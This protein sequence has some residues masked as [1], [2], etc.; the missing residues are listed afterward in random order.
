MTV[1]GLR[2]FLAL[3]VVLHHCVISYGFH[4]TGEWKLPPSPYY[5]I[6][7]QAGVSVFFMITAFLFWGRL[8]DEGKRTDWFALY[9]NRLFRI[10]PLYWVVIASMLLVVAIKT[11]F[12]MAVPPAEL[13][14]QVFQWL[15]PG[16]IKAPPTV[17]GYAATSTITAG[18]TWTLYFEWMFY[19]SLPLLGIAAVKRT[20]LGFLP[21]CIWVIFVLPDTL[22]NQYARCFVAMFAIGM[23]AASIVRRFRGMIGDSALKSMVAV[24]LLAYTLLNRST[25]YEWVSIASLGAFFVLISSGASLFG[26][27]ASRSAIRLG[28]IS[29]GIYLLQGLVITVFLSPRVLGAFATKGPAQFWLTALAITLTLACIAA[30]TYH[31]IERPCIRIGKRLAK[32]RQQQ[33]G[34]SRETNGVLP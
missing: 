19:F 2:G 14:S 13:L 23:A 31:F 25:A 9:C 3:A 22:N 10:A 33:V 12:R 8:L 24:A 26:L 17:N 15:L 11:G 21:V 32:G 7:G 6:L 34:L 16:I 4:Q 28:S 30:A 20:P 18:V 5:S 27:L 29:Y 1:D